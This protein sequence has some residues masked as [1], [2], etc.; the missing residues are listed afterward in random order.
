MCVSSH[1]YLMFQNMTTITLHV[2]HNKATQLAVGL[3]VIIWLTLQQLP[4]NSMAPLVAVQLTTSVTVLD[5]PILCKSNHR[6]A[7]SLHNVQIGLFLLRD[8]SLF[9]SVNVTID[10]YFLYPE[11]SHGL[12]KSLYHHDSKELCP[13]LNT[14]VKP[15]L[16]IFFFP[17]TQP[18]S[19]FENLGQ[20]FSSWLCSLVSVVCWALIPK[21][22]FIVKESL[23]FASGCGSRRH[24]L[25]MYLFICI[26]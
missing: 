3:H 14:T 1:V 21:W 9:L 8:F 22:N 20:S 18:P 23:F 26:L 11:P 5:L 15:Y 19:F 25:V 10:I 13:S 7:C 4:D 17:H 16:L 12:K 24:P 2:V 6:S